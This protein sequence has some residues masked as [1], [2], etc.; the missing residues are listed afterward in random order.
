MDAN[1]QSYEGRTSPHWEA[2]ERAFENYR[3][4]A[5]VVQRLNGAADPDRAILSLDSAVLAMETAR[6]Q[7][8]IC[9]DALVRDMT[10]SP[11]SQPAAG[12]P[13][14]DRIREVADLLWELEGKPDGTALSDWYR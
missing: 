4:K 8:Q 3:E 11:W 9:R 5:G 1:T 12:T 13:S 2:Y 6:E 7:Y 10:S 14:Q